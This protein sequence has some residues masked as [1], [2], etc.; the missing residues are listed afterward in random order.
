MTAVRLVDH[1]DHVAPVGEKRMLRA[2]VLLG[3]RASELLQC[4]EVDAARDPVAQFVAQLRPFAHLH[5][6]FGEKQALIER[7]EQLPVE[8]GAI[9]DDDDCGVLELVVAR[10]EIGVQ[11]HLHRLARALGV[12]DD[13]GLAVRLDRL[14]GAA[15][16]LGHREVLVRLRDALAQAGG[17]FI[18]CSEIAHELEEALLIEQ[19]VERIVDRLDRDPD[20]DAGLGEWLAVVIDVPGREMVERCE[21]RAVLRLEPVAREREHAEPER[22]RKLAQVRLQLRVGGSDAGGCRPRALQFDDAQR[23][24]VDE[25][26][27]VESTVQ[28][29]LTQG[30][31]VDSEPV[32]V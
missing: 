3:V 32:I 11:L 6:L 16:G 28:V 8:F 18:E 31:L 5:R 4:C 29:A 9:G 20:L 25:E 2:G 23:H 17:V 26:H 27:D 1:D 24:A 7:L 15:D 22:H 13:A 19:A 21:R 30:E 10:N 14:H 12:P